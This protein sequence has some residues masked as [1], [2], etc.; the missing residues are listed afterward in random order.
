MTLANS[1]KVGARNLILN[2]AELK[3]DET[4]AI[5][6]E[7]PKLGWY[8]ADVT[9]ALVKEV[10]QMGI[11]PTLL[12]VGGPTNYK[13]PTSRKPLLNAIWNSYT[14]LPKRRKAN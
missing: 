4:L 8:D 3:K 1:L 11:K 9:D 13:N 12:K 6:S 2:C 14:S 5:I 10:T 7:D